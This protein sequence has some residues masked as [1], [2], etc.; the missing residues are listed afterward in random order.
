MDKEEK[1]LILII[2]VVLVFLAIRGNFD[3]LVKDKVG[4]IE[5]PIPENIDIIKEQQTAIIQ[6]KELYF[7]KN[8]EGMKFLSQCL[9]VVG[10][11]IRYVV[12]IVNVPRIS[13]DDRPENQCE[14]YR[15]GEV[16]HFIELDRGGNIFRIV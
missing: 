15:K 9:G 11:N 12:D 16:E 3:F 13:I 6:A 14:A 4:N 1:G 10:D 8:R 2:V 5:Q 7:Q